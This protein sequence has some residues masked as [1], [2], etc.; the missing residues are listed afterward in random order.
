VLRG[1][2]EPDAKWDPV[3]ARASALVVRGAL[4]EPFLERVARARGGT[5]GASDGLTIVADDA[6]KVFLD[7]PAAARCAARGIAIEVLSP[8][9]LMALTVNPVAPSSHRFDSIQLCEALALAI[10]DVAV[11]DVVSGVVAGAALATAR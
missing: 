7:A 5:A 6:A 8:I 2:A 11:V 9:N 1:D 3:L 10:P 4:T